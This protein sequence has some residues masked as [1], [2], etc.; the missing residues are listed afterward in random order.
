M[1]RHTYARKDL[2][3][4]VRANTRDSSRGIL[5]VRPIGSAPSHLNNSMHS[6]LECSEIVYGDAQTS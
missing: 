1:F 2:D 6:D 3:C 5:Q 4:S